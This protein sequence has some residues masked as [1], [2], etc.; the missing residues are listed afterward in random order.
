MRRVLNDH[1]KIAQNGSEEFSLRK[2]GIQEQRRINV[3]LEALQHRPAQRGLSRTDVPVNNDEAL[4]ARNAIAEEFEGEKVRGTVI[5]ELRIRCQA[6]RGL[7]KSV[8]FFVHLKNHH[9]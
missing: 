4:T 7:I 2:E 1:A 5:K 8:E 3:L 9:I 6:E